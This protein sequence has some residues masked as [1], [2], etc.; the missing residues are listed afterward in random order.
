MKILKNMKK[1]TILLLVITIV[2]LVLLLRNNF[3]EIINTLSSMN[4]I[5]IIIAIIFYFLSVFFKSIA[6]YITI[7][8]KN[9][10]SIRESFKHNIIIQF[11][12]GITP[13]STGGQP[14]EI[15]MLTEHNISVMEATNLSIQSFIF[16]QI[17]LVLFGLIAVIY[18]FIFKIFPQ[19]PVLRKFVLLGFLINTLVAIILILLII[20]EK[21]TRKIAKDIIKFLSDLKIIKDKDKIEKSVY[22]KLDEFHKSAVTIRKRKGLFTKAII[23]NILSLACLYIIPLFIV[24][25]IGDYTSLNIMDS[26]VSSAYVLLIGSFV[27]IPGASGGIEFGFLQFYGN[28]LDKPVISG[29]L[30]VWRFIT[31]YLGIILGALSFSLEKKVK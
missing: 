30:I 20:S 29:V 16:Y 24:Y 23:L 11:F 6:N 13:F 8:D 21:V 3:N 26:V 1:N 12:N 17:A 15:Y 4:I 31:Y 10:V 18:N 22:T 7:N 2:I 5:F 19:S 9:K 25:S 27:P 28:F 14:M